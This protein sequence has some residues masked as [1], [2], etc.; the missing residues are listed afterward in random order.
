MHVQNYFFSLSNAQSCDV[1]SA[2]AGVVTLAPILS[3]RGHQILSSVPQVA[4]LV[5]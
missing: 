4:A 1:L 2:V 3:T 5:E